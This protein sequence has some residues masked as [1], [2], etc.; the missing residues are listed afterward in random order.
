MPH[1]WL[2]TG[3]SSG[4]GR[5][6]AQRLVDEGEQVLVTARR[7]ETIAE[8]EGRPNAVV[9]PLDVRDE[10]QCQA[11]IDLAVDRFGGLDVLVNNAGYGQFGAVEEVSADQLLAQFET[12]LFGP[13]RL[14]R[15]AL[16]QW[17][18]QGGGHAL[19]VSS[20][21][22]F[23]PYPGLSAYTASKFA[24]EGLAESLAQEAT[25]LGVRVTILQL[26]GFATGYGRAL[27]Q[28]AQP[29]DAYVPVYGEMRTAFEHFEQLPGLNDPALFADTVVR[30][31]RDPNPP[32]RVPVGPDAHAHLTAALEQRAK[33]LTAA[34]D[35]FF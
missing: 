3:C 4:V 21:A 1:R 13:W 2:V 7:P 14:L 28:P 23:T 8:F 10:A 20:T 26:G 17:R 19:F 11:A 25:H 16:P 34:G 12:N 32:L 30:V 33:Q 31:V 18:A 27:L 5:A 24:L 22:G 6:L 29:V 15:L 35:D 9:A